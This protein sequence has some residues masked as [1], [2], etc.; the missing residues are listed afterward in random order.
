VPSISITQGGDLYTV[1]PTGEE[2]FRERGIIK[3]PHLRID[4][5]GPTSRMAGDELECR[6]ATRFPRYSQGKTCSGHLY[7]VRPTT[8]RCAGVLLFWIPDGVRDMIQTKIKYADAMT[9]I[10]NAL[11]ESRAKPI[12]DAP[13][14]LSMML[15]N[16]VKIS[17]TNY[18]KEV[19][20]DY[21]FVLEKL[22]IYHGC[23]SNNPDYPKI[24]DWQPKYTASRTWDCMLPWFYTG[25]RVLVHSRKRIR[26]TEEEAIS[27]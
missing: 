27:E 19:C 11:D 8:G 22:K 17:V 14:E 13:D 2:K 23:G 3:N 7:L 20:Y 12:G 10:K 18:H 5:G 26:P 6:V 25:S 4:L 1:A 21:S 9:T 24:E 15:T 16:G